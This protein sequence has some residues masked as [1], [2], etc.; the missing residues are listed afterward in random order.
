MNTTASTPQTIGEAILKE[1]RD[2]RQEVTT[3]R[4]FAEMLGRGDETGESY[5]SATSRLLGLLVGGTEKTHASLEALHSLMTEPGIAR[6]LRRA[7]SD[8]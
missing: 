2:L 3:L 5:M 6:A 1:V 7:I 4:Q 8:E